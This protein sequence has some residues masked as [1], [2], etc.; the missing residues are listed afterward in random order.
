[1]TDNDLPSPV[2][3]STS[4]G[5]ASQ[6]PPPPTLSPSRPNDPPSIATSVAAPPPLP[7]ASSAVSILP[8]SPIPQ[9]S[10]PQ[11][12]GPPGLDERE[13][14]DASFSQVEHQYTLFLA[15][16]ALDPD[17]ARF[18][19]EY[20]KLHR[21]LLRSRAHWQRTLAQYEELSLERNANMASTIEASKV[22]AQD[23][24][25]A[26]QLRIH[27]KKTEESVV[28]L[29]KRDQ[30]VK[31]EL[32]LLQID[33]AA[34]HATI[35]QGVSLSVM[36]ERTLAELA[37]AKDT[38][39]KELEHEMERIVE[40]RAQVATTTEAIRAVDMQ[41]R[42]LE[43]DI[44]SLRDRNA[45][46]KADIET[47]TRTKDRLERELRDLRALVSTKSIEIRSR[48]DQSARAA[49]DVSILEHQ[50][51]S[52]KV[53]AEKLLK[54]QETL[55]ARTLKF[56]EECDEQL[57]TTNILF[58]EN[59]LTAKEL[60]AKEAEVSKTRLE[61]KRVKKLRDALI[62]RNRHLEA[63][64]TLAEMNRQSIRERCDET[65]AECEQ[66]RRENDASKKL[67][68]E[69][70]RERDI[71]YQNIGKNVN[72]VI[73]TSSLTT[74]YTQDRHNIEI[75]VQRYKRDLNFQEKQ[76]KTL[77]HERDALIAEAETLHQEAAVCLQEIHNK[78][79]ETAEHKRKMAQANTKLK[80]QQNLYEAVQSERNLNSKQLLDLQA[81]I[82]ELRR[83]LKL[84]SFQINGRKDEINSKADGLSRE[85]S[86]SAKLSKDI[87]A[88]Q[89]EIKAVRQQT[90]VAAAYMKTQIAEEAKLHHFVK[91]A[92]VERARQE[93]ALQAL[94]AE[95]ANLHGR[96]VCLN[97]ELS[98]VYEKLKLQRSTLLRGE[99]HYRER[100]KAANQAR[101]QLRKLSQEKSLALAF[102][103]G[104]EAL[105]KMVL[106]LQ[107]ALVREQTRIKALEE[108][109]ANPVNVHR[110][111]NLES[112]DPKSY[113]AIQLLHTLQKR[114]I[115]R[116]KEDRE[117]EDK[118]RDCEEAYLR[119]KTVLQ[120][121]TSVDWEEKTEEYAREVKDRHI[122]LKALDTEMEMY[123]ARTREAQYEVSKLDLQLE[124]LKNHYL[125]WRKQAAKTENY[126]GTGVE[127]S[128]HTNLS[129]NNSTSL[130][131]LPEPPHGITTACPRGY[132][133]RLCKLYIAIMLIPKEN[134]K[135]IYQ[136]LFQAGV[137][138]A[139]KD[140]NAPKH[141]DI[142]VP[143]L[144]VIKAMQSMNSRGYVTTQF[145]WQYFYYYLTDQG[146][147]YL[148]EYLHLPPEIVPN[149]LMKS[150]STGIR[151]GGDRADRPPRSDGGAFRRERGEGEYRRRDGGDKEGA[152]S[153]FRPE[154][155]GGMGRGRPTV[156]DSQ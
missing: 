135:K 36:Q 29:E 22:V 77:I 55:A 146:I 96:I 133:L 71:L 9:P 85:S 79:I 148:R 42:H 112:T 76:L 32:K 100:F 45:Q 113:E 122:K 41:K 54:D 153:A 34:L 59:A 155:R 17:L 87:D 142:E 147:E 3:S 129:S 12:P 63:Q 69:L 43:Q 33:V 132:W 126:G 144:Q 11:L 106:R 105:R 6:L 137:M 51:K 154:F 124:D 114:L 66:L 130:P 57:Y 116:T 67:L 58:Q 90:E 86:E 26:R 138:V 52:Q 18:K 121:H 123:R 139:K 94:L 82:A 80:H 61:M 145:S 140:F 50:I 111:R 125:E 23:Q 25:I 75:E 37:Q 108:E 72:Q 109:L 39:A 49:D 38:S 68:D 128:H 143:N 40:L 48:Q 127:S 97:D 150:K 65:A 24:E 35:K 44:C 141:K 83:K 89:E 27:I 15:V 101:S 152:G 117:K 104:S 5:S 21:V 74:R 56:K 46:K 115:A 98:Q 156:Q 30:G 19:A 88:I 131:P 95:Q 31:D 14:Q 20:E 7:S 92:D 149:T 8:A 151:P 64:K 4:S 134:R 70:S 99:G 47:E 53:M 103:E 119:L 10:V 84:A 81:E 93:N 2:G 62:K 110:W 118:I 120:K 91:E 16:L 136:Y 73:K 28:S 60:K 102:S 13:K 78:Q 1:M 107:E